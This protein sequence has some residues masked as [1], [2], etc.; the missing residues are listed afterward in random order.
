MVFR[1]EVLRYKNGLKKINKYAQS[2][3]FTWGFSVSV[4]FSSDDSIAPC[5]LSLQLS[6][7]GS[8]SSPLNAEALIWGSSARGWCLPALPGD[9]PAGRSPALGTGGTK[10]RANAT[11]ALGSPAPFS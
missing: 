2:W 6:V 4:L 11:K 3:L 8:Q 1:D 5:P 7:D 10:Q 9:P